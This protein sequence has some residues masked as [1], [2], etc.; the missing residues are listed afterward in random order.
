MREERG[1]D[2]EE[3]AGKGGMEDSASSYFHE[4]PDKVCNH[5]S[6]PDMETA[7]LQ[8][9]N[10]RQASSAQRMELWGRPAQM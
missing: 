1:E 2:Q 3:R 5:V 7:I 9:P 10:M 4:T 6:K 8:F